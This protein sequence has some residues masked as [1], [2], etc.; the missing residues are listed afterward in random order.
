MVNGLVVLWWACVNL[1]TLSIYQDVCW[2]D[3]S[4]QTVL[5]VNYLVPDEFNNVFLDNL[6]VK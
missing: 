4:E 2:C 1:N 3:G 5:M 6:S